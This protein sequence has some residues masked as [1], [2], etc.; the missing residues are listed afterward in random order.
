MPHIRGG[1]T[2][3][4]TFECTTQYCDCLSG[5]FFPDFALPAELDAWEWPLGK[6]LGKY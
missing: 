1:A 4:K 2:R 5:I 6:D 3:V